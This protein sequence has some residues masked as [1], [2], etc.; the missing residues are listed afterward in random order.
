MFYGL[1]KNN[2]DDFGAKIERVVAT[3]PC[4]VASPTIPGVPLGSP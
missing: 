2:F 1:A 3:S 4:F